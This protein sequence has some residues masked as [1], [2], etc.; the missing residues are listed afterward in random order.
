[1]NWEDFASSTDLIYI[2]ES[3]LFE[4]IK[5]KSLPLKNINN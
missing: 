5:C 2:Y 3:P 1:M 4:I